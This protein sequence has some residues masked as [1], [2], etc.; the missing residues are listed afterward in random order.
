[1]ISVYIGDDVKDI[2]EDVSLTD[3]NGDF[4]DNVDDLNVGVVN[5]DCC[6]DN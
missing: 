2:D 3:D 6:G 4:N 1:M 5:D